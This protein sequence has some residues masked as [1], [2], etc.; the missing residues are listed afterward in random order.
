MSSRD[1]AG[2]RKWRRRSVERRPS[3]R[4]GR[5]AGPGYFAPSAWSTRQEVN[6]RHG[7]HDVTS[8]TCLQTA[9]RFGTYCGFRTLD[10]GEFSGKLGETARGV[11][12]RNIQRKNRP[13]N[14]ER[15]RREVSESSS[16]RRTRLGRSDREENRLYVSIYFYQH[17]LALKRTVLTIFIKVINTLDPI[18]TRTCSRFLNC[19][20]KKQTLVSDENELPEFLNS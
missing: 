1:P 16:R 13:A 19:K 5:H 4:G 2:K 14:V 12:T 10:I 3:S 17:K 20:N 11:A 8:S 18:V 7:V 6:R 15:R 9:S